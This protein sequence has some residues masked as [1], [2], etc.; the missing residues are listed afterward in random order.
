MGTD[1]KSQR[2]HNPAS[3]LKALMGRAL[4]QDGT[5]PTQEVWAAVMDTQSTDLG[6]LYQGVGD[7]IRLVKECRELLKRADDAVLQ[8]C[9]PPL[10]AIEQAFL[11]F[12][13]RAK[14]SQFADRINEENLLYGLKVCEY[15]LDTLGGEQRAAARDLKQLR[16]QIVK[17]LEDTEAAEL[18]QFL[19]TFLLKHLRTML[20]A[21]DHYEIEGLDAL[22]AATEQTIGGVYININNLVVGGAGASADRADQRPAF[23]KR[24]GGILEKAISLIARTHAVDAI[25]TKVIKRLLESGIPPM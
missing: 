9:E 14:W 18:D 10:S 11:N 22:Q 13:F 23:L 17:L 6:T 8:I 4:Q 24:L 19:K 2:P 25:A 20:R 7:V 15:Q 21:I 12:N 1:R 3:R 16:E 5:K